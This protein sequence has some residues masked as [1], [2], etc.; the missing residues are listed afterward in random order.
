V[1]SSR[2]SLRNAKHCTTVDAPAFVSS[3][4]L[5]APATIRPSSGPSIDDHTTRWRIG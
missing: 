5:L 1:C 2:G 4:V 3:F